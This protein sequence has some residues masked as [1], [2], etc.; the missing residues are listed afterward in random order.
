MIFSVKSPKKAQKPVE[1][2]IKTRFS[3]VFRASN[4]E[5]G[6]FGKLIGQKQAAI[7]Q[8]VSGPREPS[9][10]MLRGVVDKLEISPEW[11]YTGT[12]SMK[13]APAT[14]GQ[15]VTREEFDRLRDD[16]E[17][18]SA[19]IQFLLSLVPAESRPGVLP[20]RFR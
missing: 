3:A 11:L 1:S 13:K 9:K 16:V 8:V 20:K 19:V 5:Q 6:D 2:E 17:D 4:L 18:A 10:A 14:T 7:S 12:G 15:P